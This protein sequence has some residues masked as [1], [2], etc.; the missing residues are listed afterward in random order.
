[1]LILHDKKEHSLSFSLLTSSIFKS[2]FK[3]MNYFNHIFLYKDLCWGFW[4]LAAR[5]KNLKN[6][7][8]KIRENRS[9]QKEQKMQN[10][11]SVLAPEQEKE[12]KYFYC[13]EHADY[14]QNPLFVLSQF[15]FGNIYN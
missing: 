5:Q 9:K 4:I 6:Q 11:F 8:T 10:E 7:D 3:K 2:N 15:S 12:L 13:Y 1:M 14:S